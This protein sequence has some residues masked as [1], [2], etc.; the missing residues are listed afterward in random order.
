VALPDPP[1]CLITSELAT[2]AQVISTVEAALAGGIRWIQLRR[3]HDT[4]RCL[5][6]L[7]LRLKAAADAYDATLIVND[8]VDIALA[9]GAGGVHLPASGMAPETAARLL[10]S[11]RQCGTLVGRSVH[12]AA[13]IVDPENRRAD[14]FQFGPVFD[15]PSKRAF[16]KAQGLPALEQAV[17]TAA[18]RP[19]VAV[20]G[21]DREEASTVAGTGVAGIAMI[22][23]FA[24]A[25]D[26]RHTALDLIAS[27]ASGHA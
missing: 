8:R 18:G 23:A 22:G 25:D 26:P 4:G 21:I 3:R 16:G 10:E 15:T 24:N 13:E 7:S 27:F 17:H 9:C 5:Y 6:E 12:S 2:A 11:A 1:I 20:G 19:L 14:Y